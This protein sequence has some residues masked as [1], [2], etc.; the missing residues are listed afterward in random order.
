MMTDEW[1][2]N[3]LRVIESESN[4]WMGATLLGHTTQWLIVTGVRPVQDESIR[5]ELKAN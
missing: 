3:D 2:I 4:E 1:I 5:N